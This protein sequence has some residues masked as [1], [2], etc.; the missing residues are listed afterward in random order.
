MKRFGGTDR[1]ASWLRNSTY[2]QENTTIA[3]RPTWRKMMNLHRDA[4]PLLP[5]RVIALSVSE[6]RL[7]SVDCQ[8]PVIFRAYLLQ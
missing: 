5:V 4:M 6:H 7:F 1:K 2:C 3:L 8:I